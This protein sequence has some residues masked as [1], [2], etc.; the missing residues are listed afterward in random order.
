VKAKAAPLL[1]T[2]VYLGCAVRFV[3]DQGTTILDGLSAQAEVNYN[4]PPKTLM[5]LHGSDQI[6][7][8]KPGMLHPSGWTSV[9]PI[10]AIVPPIHVSH[11]TLQAV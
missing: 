5:R 2:T 1:W 10:G 4:S 3:H 11:E 8:G 9:R 7:G 6:I